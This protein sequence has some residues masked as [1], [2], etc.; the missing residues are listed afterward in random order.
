MS[1]SPNMIDQLSGINDTRKVN[2]RDHGNQWPALPVGSKILHGSCDGVGLV[3][4]C[5]HN[6]PDETTMA[7]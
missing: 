1:S 4:R 5:G 7:E 2:V 6:G 3:R